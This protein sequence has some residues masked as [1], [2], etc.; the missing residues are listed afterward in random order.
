MGHIVH[1]AMALVG[2]LAWCAEWVV[3]RVYALRLVIEVLRLR[4]VRTYRGRRWLAIF[5][6]AE[7]LPRRVIRTEGGA[8]YLARYLVWGSF[9]AGTKVW[10][11]AFTT[12][13]GVVRLPT[14]Y[15]GRQT[16]V[17]LYLHK[18]YSADVDDAP[19]SHPWRWAV[20]VCLHGGYT[21]E[22]TH[23][24]TGV[25]TR[26]RIRPGSINVLRGDTFHRVAVLDE[27]D[28]TWTLFLAGPRTAGW[29][30]L[31]PGR[32]YVRHIERLAERG[33]S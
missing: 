13:R 1:G 18:F 25:V 2:W 26:R 6:L 27:E 19:H 30:F 10:P 9:P 22:R 5:D 4:A 20:S 28:E 32:G 24:P 21:E 16:R 31:V 15:A 33:L 8:P 12:S 14:P 11:S 29:G 17:S 7:R 23:V 3:V